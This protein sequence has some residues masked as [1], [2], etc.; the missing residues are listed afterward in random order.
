M[1][2]TIVRCPSE[3]KFIDD[4]RTPVHHAAA[5]VEPDLASGA[6]VA[7]QV[8]DDPP[9]GHAI[10]MS[11]VH[12]TDTPL[13]PAGRWFVDRLKED[14]AARVKGD[15]SASVDPIGMI[16]ISSHPRLL[17]SLRARLLPS[18]TAE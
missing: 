11:A 1:S 13:G 4:K 8:E 10:A 12:L 9:D 14:A 2:F 18:V 16:P 15:K 6:L 3:G 5:R 17:G 7:I